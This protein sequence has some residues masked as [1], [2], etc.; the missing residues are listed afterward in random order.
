MQSTYTHTYTIIDHIPFGC[1][2]IVYMQLLTSFMQF[3][4]MH[5]RCLCIVIETSQS[6]CLQWPGLSATMCC[7]PV[8]E[9]PAS[10]AMG[11]CYDNKEFH[12]DYWMT[13]SLIGQQLGCEGE[14]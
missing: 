6:V 3:S 4:H 7:T 1:L 11:S 2:L 5:D 9:A 13:L 8:R 10:A 14:S 12:I